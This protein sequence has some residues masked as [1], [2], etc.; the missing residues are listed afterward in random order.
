MLREVPVSRCDKHDGYS[1]GCR[2]CLR[3][4]LDRPW[5][6]AAPAP[7]VRDERSWEEFE[8]ARVADPLAEAGHA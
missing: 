7:E 6:G 3:A 4:W 8:L 1:D 2:D 5:T